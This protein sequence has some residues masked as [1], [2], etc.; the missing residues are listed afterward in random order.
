VVLLA[1][2]GWGL[3]QR[4]GEILLAL[5]GWVLVQRM[6][7]ILALGGLADWALSSKETL[8][9]WGWESLEWES[10]WREGELKL[11]L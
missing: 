8:V 2:A 11:G 10:A 3:V 9:I 7:E 6:G 4:V 5:A 1:L